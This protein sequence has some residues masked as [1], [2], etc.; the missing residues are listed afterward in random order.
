MIAER[1]R[2]AIVMICAVT[3]AA[4]TGESGARTSTSRLE[5]TTTTTTSTTTTTTIPTT[6]TTM[7]PI[8][9]AGAPPGLTTAVES[10]YA[11]ARGVSGLIDNVPEP[12]MP[13]AGSH[14]DLPTVTGTARLSEFRGA[15][16]AVVQAG[17]DVLAFTNPGDGW[18]LVAG[19]APSVG[20]EPWYGGKPWLVAIVGSDARRGQNQDTA[21]S[22]S[23]HILGM[24]T[25]GG[26]S[27]VG[28]PRDSYVSI[29]GHGRSKINAALSIGGPELMLETFESVSGLELDGYVLTGFEG[30][31]RM[32]NGV[33]LPFDMEISKGFTDRAAKAD[34]ETGVEEMNG[35]KAL[36]FSRARK[37]FLRGDFQRQI[38]GGW[39]LL[40]GL[41]GAKL[42]GPLAVPDMI[43]GTERWLSTDLSPDQLLQLALA[44][45]R[46]NPAQVDNIVLEGGTGFAGRASVVYLSERA[47]TTTFEDLADGKLGN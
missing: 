38:N 28:I 31:E 6:T 1:S 11:V 35:K 2:L 10:Y 25:S 13:A 22:D 17:S 9:I 5:V 39:V 30:F 8:D 12:L 44:A 47:T 18:Q 19:A 26:G 36:A 14:P 4:C 32:V 41:G 45:L 33:L 46:L 21:R 20:V 7:Q 34:F 15:G 24:D 16:I 29:P 37:A 42:R 43:A 3:V 23:I 40:G 27:L